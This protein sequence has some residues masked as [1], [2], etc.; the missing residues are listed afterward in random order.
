MS[1][2]PN[3]PMHLA[4]LLGSGAQKTSSDFDLNSDPKPDLSYRDAAVL[5]PLRFENSAWQVILTKRPATMKHH[6]GQV[7]F[8]GGKK[9]QSDPNL[10]MTAAREAG[11]EI[12]L[13]PSNLQWL[14]ELPKHQTV[15]GFLVSPFVAVI[16]QGQ[17]LTPERYEVEEVFS[18]PLAHFK[19][20][21]FRK[22]GRDWAGA[23]RYYYTIPYGPYYIWGA[24]ARILLNLALA[25]ECLDAD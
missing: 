3:L 6:P 17:T 1:D 10:Q 13:E 21:R 4:K 16:E 22:E 24:T 23:A 19:S 25:M 9:E 2:N 12:G 14:G 20:S 8:P 15:T 18:V 7:A 5:V 11:E